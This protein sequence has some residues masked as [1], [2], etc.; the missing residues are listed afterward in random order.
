MRIMSAQST[1]Q[2]IV[3]SAVD[4]CVKIE[5]RYMCVCGVCAACVCARALVYVYVYV[6]VCMCKC[7][8]VCVCPCTCVRARTCVCIC[9]CFQQGFFNDTNSHIS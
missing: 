7:V 2:C 1:A 8:C 5:R 3:G 4:Q 9:Q 6:C